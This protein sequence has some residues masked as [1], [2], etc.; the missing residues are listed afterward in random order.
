M[1]RVND[2]AMF[3]QVLVV[4]S[5]EHK[6]TLCLVKIAIWWHCGHS[7]VDNCGL[8]V[9]VILMTIIEMTSYSM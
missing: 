6:T 5:V 4:A 7:F 2:N 8:F 1:T 9:A 3:R